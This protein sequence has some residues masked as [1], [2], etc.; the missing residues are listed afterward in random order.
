MLKNK[1][2]HERDLLWVL[3]LR[4]L[5]CRDLWPKAL[6]LK[7]KSYWPFQHLRFQHLSFV[8]ENALKI[9]FATCPRTNLFDHLQINSSYIKNRLNY[10]FYN[11]YSLMILQISPHFFPFILLPTFEISQLFHFIIWISTIISW[12]LTDTLR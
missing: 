1:K 3:W 8:A 12:S 7:L 11:S 2:A 5:W 10:L 4:I 6:H 9:T